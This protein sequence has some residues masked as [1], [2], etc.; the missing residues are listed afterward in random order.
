MDE[1]AAQQRQPEKCGRCLEPL[2]HN[3]AR[4]PGCG[5][6]VSNTRR[7]VFMAVATAGAL[8]LVFLIV[9]MYVS[10]YRGGLE[11]AVEPPAAEPPVFA[12]GETSA[13]HQSEAP[14]KDEGKP[15][16]TK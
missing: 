16:S 9:I 1:M 8:A 14:K 4:C 15:A 3:A 2:P 11:P 10:V 5:Q 7:M 13:E 12:G 6:P